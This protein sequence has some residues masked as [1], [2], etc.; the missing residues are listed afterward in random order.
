MSREHRFGTS[1]KFGKAG[2]E[3]VLDFLSNSGVLTGLKKIKNVTQDKEYQQK[4]ID[5]ILY[6]ENG[7]EFTAEI[8]TDSYSDSNNIVYE[9]WSSKEDQIPGCMYVCQADY[10]YYYFPGNGELYQLKMDK[11]REWVE[12]NA[13]RKNFREISVRNT[14][15]GG[16]YNSINY[17]IPK[18]MLKSSFKDWRTWNIRQQ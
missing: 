2:E 18:S 5:A 14:Y 12:K 15:W 16:E 6:F 17:L 13:A 8:K 3:E 9:V 11:Y 10:L 7:K 4:D 1:N